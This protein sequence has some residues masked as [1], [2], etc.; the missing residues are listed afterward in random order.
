MDV[1]QEPFNDFRSM[2]HTL[3]FIIH[4]IAAFAFGYGPHNGRLW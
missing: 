1:Y 2:R 4:L 3:P